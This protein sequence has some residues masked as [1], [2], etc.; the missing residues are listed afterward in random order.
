MTQVPASVCN[1]I[2]PQL[3]MMLTNQLTQ[4]LSVTDLAL[5]PGL[6]AIL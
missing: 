4:T 5:L 1:A 2:L 6:A 3:L